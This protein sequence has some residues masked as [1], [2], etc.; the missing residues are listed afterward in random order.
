MRKKLLDFRTS[1]CQMPRD[2][3]ETEEALVELVHFLTARSGLPLNKVKLFLRTK[4]SDS[5]VTVLEHLDAE[6][7]AFVNRLKIFINQS[8][9]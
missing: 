8:E 4:M 3:R 5:D 1:R 2:F 7:R 6:G 9:D